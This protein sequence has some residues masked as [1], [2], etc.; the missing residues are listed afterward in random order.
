MRTLLTNLKTLMK[1]DASFSDVK[2][3][4]RGVLP[5]VP[6][7]PCIAI[8]PVSE[9][10]GTIF[11]GGKYYTE[12]RVNIEAFVAG[13]N[14]Q[15]AVNAAMDWVEKIKEF[16]QVNRRI[17]GT[18][19]DTTTGRESLG[20][21]FPLRQAFIQQAIVPIT[22]L[23]MEDFPSLTITS[24]LVEVN[25]GDL[26]DQIFTVVSGFKSTTLDNVKYIYKRA[27]KDLPDFPV[28]GV[29]EDSEE[30]LH[31]WAGKEGVDRGF[32][33]VTWNKLADK[34]TM[35]DKVLDITE[36]LRDILWSN[37]SFGGRVIESK[38]PRIDFGIDEWNET[39]LYASTIHLMCRSK[40][41]L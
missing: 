39:M 30:F 35:L 28:V 36:V 31:T 13:L 20:E 19:R 5:P 26:L 34:E 7:F 22:V 32:R 38:I 11:A 12:R 21:S 15:T 24:D 1:A 4:K 16:V 3:W 40:E 29:L 6:T 27:I 33:L 10:P 25:S 37:Y 23:F 41:N 18:A 17:N 2:T 8:L 9:T 14:P